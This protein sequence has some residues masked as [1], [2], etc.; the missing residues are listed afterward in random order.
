MLYWTAYH[1]DIK[2]TL[3]RYEQKQ[4]RNGTSRSHSPT[5][6]TGMVALRGFGAGNTIYTRTVVYFCTFSMAAS[7]D[8]SW[9]DDELDLL[10]RCAL[11]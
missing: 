8:F 10:L 9:T 6:H 4:P 7:K 5:D 1:V 2:T 3:A 11:V